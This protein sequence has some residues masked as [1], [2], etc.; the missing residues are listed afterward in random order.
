MARVEQATNT[1]Q[2]AAACWSD[3]EVKVPAVAQGLQAQGG[4]A[5][6]AMAGRVVEHPLQ[7]RQQADARSR[8]GNTRHCN[9]DDTD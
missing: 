4:E 3:L 2:G 9:V 1:K 8:Y 5:R 7:H 6:E